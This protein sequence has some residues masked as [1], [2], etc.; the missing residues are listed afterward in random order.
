MVSIINRVINRKPAI[1]A[2]TLAV[3]AVSPGFAAGGAKGTPARTLTGGQKLDNAPVFPVPIYTGNVLA[4]N[5]MQV[6]TA[7]GLALTATTRTAD[8]PSLPF[9]WY[10]NFL[11]RNDWTVVL[12]KNESASPSERNGNLLMLKAS[13]DNTSLLIICSKMQRSKFTTVNVTTMQTK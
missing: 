5:Y 12:P 13:K 3:L 9:A 4:T 7:N 10:Q 6:P 2:L 11:S 8:D 1:M